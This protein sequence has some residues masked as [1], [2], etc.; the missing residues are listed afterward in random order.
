MNDTHTLTHK[1][2]CYLYLWCVSESFQSVVILSACG[3]Y[4]WE[5]MFGMKEKLKGEYSDT[6]R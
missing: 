6:F 5:L 3:N 2:A 4:V 1:N